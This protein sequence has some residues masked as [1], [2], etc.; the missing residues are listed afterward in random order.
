MVLAVAAL[1]TD[2]VIAAATAATNSSCST[3]NSSNGN[4]NSGAKVAPD[5]TSIN[6][7]INIEFKNL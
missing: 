6:T 3:S 7:S 4:R 2:A 5:I 1:I